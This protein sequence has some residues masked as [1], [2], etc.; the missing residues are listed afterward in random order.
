MTGSLLGS[1][2][3]GRLAAIMHSVIADWRVFVSPNL[4]KA[5]R[6]RPALSPSRNMWVAGKKGGAVSIERDPLPLYFYR[7]SGR[8][9]RGCLV[10]G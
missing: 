6:H 9:G 1:E 7:F 10:G 5:R 8:G 3:K 4:H 2:G